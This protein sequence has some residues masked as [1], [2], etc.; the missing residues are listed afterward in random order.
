MAMRRGGAGRRRIGTARE[1]QR[2]A[3]VVSELVWEIHGALAI[4]IV[5]ETLAR[6][7]PTPYVRRMASELLDQ[8]YDPPSEAIQR[9]VLDHL[10]PFH[11][12]YLSVA[13]FFCFATG[14]S[15]GLDVSP[16]GGPPGFVRVLDPKTVMFADFPGNNRIESLR[17][18]VQD[19]RAAMLFIFPGLE[20]FMRINGRAQISTDAERLAQLAE[21]GRLP[22][23]AV[24]LTVDEV[25]FHCGKAI[26]RARLWE[27]AS[28]IDRQT[29]P[30]VG[31]MKTAL[32]SGSEEDARRVDAEYDHVVKTKL[33]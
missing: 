14:R 3:V 13:T 11:I 8:L 30:T 18:L 31:Q 4:S 12:Q 33:Y 26:N 24:V 21:G 32:T 16:R 19:P 2:T 20:V 9:G 15:H 29:L 1:D 6:A 27:P 5:L 10:V 7:L 22:K 23:T 25:L 28:R 17:N